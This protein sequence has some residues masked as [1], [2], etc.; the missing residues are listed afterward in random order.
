MNTIQVDCES[1]TVVQGS[2][3]FLGTTDSR[4]LK[5]TDSNGVVVLFFKN[6]LNVCVKG[7]VSSDC[8]IPSDYR[9]PG[10]ED[11]Y[12]VVNGLIHNCEGYLK[13]SSYA[14]HPAANQTI[15]SFFAEIV[16][17]INS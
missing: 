8:R 3:S 6:T 5:I 2:H 13:E 15:E 1:G 12:I 16:G 4:L 9:K 10:L 14:L 7:L 17:L 11:P